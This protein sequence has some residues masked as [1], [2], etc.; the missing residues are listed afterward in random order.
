MGWA[1]AGLVG[2]GMFE[3]GRAVFGSAFA[4]DDA[5]PYLAGGIIIAAAVYQLTPL[6]D[7]CLRNCRSPLMFLMKH[8]APG[9]IGAVADGRRARRLVR[10]LLLD[11]D[12]GAVRARRDEPGLDGVH[13]RLDR[14][15]EAPAV[16]GAAPTA[17]SPI[18]LLVLGLSVAFVPES[19]PG[20]TLPGVA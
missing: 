15:G 5:G 3:L 12:G 6:K 1:A 18:L 10:R 17:G 13:R 11:A 8:S 16:A 7:V 4:W 9:R 2:Y 20:L 19:V 14:G